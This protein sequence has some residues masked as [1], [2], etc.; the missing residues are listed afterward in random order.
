VFANV[1][2]KEEKEEGMADQSLATMLQGEIPAG[3]IGRM[4]RSLE[5]HPL[6]GWAK[7]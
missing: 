2:S 7:D 4:C 3:W 5:H 6:K 1:A